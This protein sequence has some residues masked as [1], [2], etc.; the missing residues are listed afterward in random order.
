MTTWF[1]VAWATIGVIKTRLNLI[2]TCSCAL[3]DAGLTALHDPLALDEYS[4]PGAFGRGDVSTVDGGLGSVMYSHPEFAGG[5][6]AVT[7]PCGHGGVIGAPS[8]GVRRAHRG[9]RSLARCVVD[10]VVVEDRAPDVDDA[11]QEQE[12]HRRNQG[13]LDQSL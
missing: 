3:P 12:E 13:E 1:A 2:V 7:G 8:I 9:A 5:V 11:E 6:V 4:P 10:R